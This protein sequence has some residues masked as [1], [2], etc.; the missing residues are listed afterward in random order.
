MAGLELLGINGTRVSDTGLACLKG[1][2]NLRYLNVNGS[3]C[4]AAGVH[5]LQ[6]ALQYTAIRP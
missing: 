5:D 2:T 3:K 6:E 1:L 4:T